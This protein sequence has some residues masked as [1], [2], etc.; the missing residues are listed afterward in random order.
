M[1][2]TGINQSACC[3]NEMLTLSSGYLKAAPVPV[4]ITQKW[5]ETFFFQT[6]T[7]ADGS[8]TLQKLWIIFGCMVISM[9]G[10]I[11]K[12]QGT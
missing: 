2:S 4:V 7:T 11:R 3:N 12:I 5:H 6:V 9:G 1:E 8:R 10:A